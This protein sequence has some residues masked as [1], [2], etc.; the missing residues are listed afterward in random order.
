[1]RSIDEV[2]AEAAGALPEDLF[3]YVGESWTLSQYPGYIAEIGEMEDPVLRLRTARDWVRLAEEHQL[4]VRPRE[5]TEFLAGLPDTRRR[6]RRARG[7][8]SN[9]AVTPEI[10]ADARTRLLWEDGLARIDDQRR[11]LHP[12]SLDGLARN[13]PRWAEFDEFA[14]RLG[15]W[16]DRLEDMLQ[17]A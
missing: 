8:I 2:E 6:R 4:V 12:S 9:T 17:R 7:A 5:A 10:R 14:R 1:M 3:A 16:L 15:G 11:R 13:D